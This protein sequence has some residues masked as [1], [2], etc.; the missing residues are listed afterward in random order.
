LTAG[1]A[2]ARGG[3]VE[4][5]VRRLLRPALWLLVL[6]PAAALAAG[7]VLGTLGANPV[8][9]LEKRSGIWA[10]R[11]LAGS[12]AVA[13]LM[14]ATGWGWLVGSR[15]FLGLAAFCWALGH[16]A[17]YFSLDMVLDVAA[18][19]RD[20][21]KHP[22]NGVGM[23]ALLLLVPL[24]VTSTAGWVKRLGGRRW[25]A[26]H[27]LVY[28]AAV[29]ALVHLLLA[30]KRDLTGPAIY[31]A[32]FGLLLGWRLLRIRGGRSGP[33][34]PRRVTGDRSASAA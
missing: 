5:L 33:R 4:R 20:V 30:T 27:R 32:V 25:R 13:P 8:E 7:L 21:T 14:R 15:R 23:L 29:V 18:M 22:R 28:V 17:V 6:G 31:A 11:F 9:T 19:L 2:G 10:L 3:G 34:V 1:A 26:L 24:A 12:L 16:F